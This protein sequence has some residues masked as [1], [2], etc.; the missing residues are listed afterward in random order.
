MKFHAPLVPGTLIRRYKRFLADVRLDDGTVVCAHIANSGAMIGLK[1]EGL[2]VWLSPALNPKRKLAFTW[3]LAEIEDGLVGVNTAHPNAI[4]A[5]AILAGRVP[6]LRGYETLKREVPYGE[7]SRIDIL[8]TSP[9]RP[10]CLVEIKNVHLRRPEIAGGCH[11]EFPDAVTAR[12][13]KHLREMAAA[14]A[15]GDRAVMLYLVQRTDCTHFALASDI[16]PAYAEAFAVA[17]KAG[18]EALCYTCAIS[19]IGL[20]LDRPL[21]LAV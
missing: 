9:D 18:V 17:R 6:E 20:T 7:N 5:E 2:R 16:D 19:T 3:E 14:V 8:L 1:D 15:A 11:A 13:A 21:P 10:R 4:V 12:G